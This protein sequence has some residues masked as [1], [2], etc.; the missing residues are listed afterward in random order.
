M[1]FSQS[2]SHRSRVA[3]TLIELLVVVAII[4]I[5]AALILP[6]VNGMIKKSNA[7][8]GLS[9]MKQIGVAMTLFSGENNGK[10]P[11]M[12]TDWPPLECGLQG[13]EPYLDTVNGKGAGKVLYVCPNRTIK[14][15]LAD[16]N[17]YGWFNYRTF[18]CNPNVIK[19]SGLP[20]DQ[21]PS[22]SISVL[23]IQ[24]PSQVISI[25]DGAQ[26]SGGGIANS[27]LNGLPVD[28]SLA[29]MTN[30]SS[31]DDLIPTTGD[32]DP[33]SSGYI[34]YRQPGGVANALFVDGHVE[35]VKKGTLKNRNFAISY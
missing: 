18:S 7:S 25:I 19:N 22:D 33:Q 23:S 26:N 6:A 1:T 12:N 17:N 8:K 21:K 14:A 32:S 35:G 2:N 3:F 24:R 13:L 28:P 5:L 4:G 10:L 20:N 27:G 15:P 34:R 9:N 16:M 31:A 30:A 29:V 11:V